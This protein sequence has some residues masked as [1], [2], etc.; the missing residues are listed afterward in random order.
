VVFWRGEDFMRN[1]RTS[2]GRR[3]RRSESGKV[4]ATSSGEDR[5]QRK[6][7]VNVGERRFSGEGAATRILDGFSR[8]SLGRTAKNL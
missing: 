7:R 2:I 5:H 4:C 6:G 3:R 1:S 8:G